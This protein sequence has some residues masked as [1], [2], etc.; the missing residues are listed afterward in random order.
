MWTEEIPVKYSCFLS[1]FSFPQANTVVSK[2]LI[3]I[4]LDLTSQHKSSH[5]C[6]P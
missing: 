3:Y 6:A 4:F 5:S 2:N 1:F